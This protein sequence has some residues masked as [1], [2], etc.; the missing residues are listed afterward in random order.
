MEQK[1]GIG[2][3]VLSKAGRDKGNYF[4]IMSLDE[5]FAQIC[6]GDIRKI[7]KPK[8]KK[9]KHIKKIEVAD[10]Y[11]KDKLLGEGDVTNRELRRAI[12]KFDET[13]G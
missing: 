13:L 3:I 6:D 8:K 4:V 2:D 1:F 12:S 7:D 5:M 10:K 11:I 9:L